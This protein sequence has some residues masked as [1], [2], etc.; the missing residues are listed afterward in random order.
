MTDLKKMYST[1]LGDSFPMEMTI[2]FGDQT[3]VYRKKTWKINQE[4]G[5]T[6][7]RGLRYGENPDQEAAL[8]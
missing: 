8:Y 3:L 7:E 2:T 4:D 6:E 1:L 5:T